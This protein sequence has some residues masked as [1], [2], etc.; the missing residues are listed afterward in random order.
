MNASRMRI[1]RERLLRAPPPPNIVLP[2]HAVNHCHR[3]KPQIQ[4]TGTRV[5]LCCGS[6]Q[7]RERSKFIFSVAYDGELVIMPYNCV[8][9]SAVSL[10]DYLSQNLRLYQLLIY[11]GYCYCLTAIAERLYWFAQRDDLVAITAV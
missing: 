4:R 1:Q 7:Q 2:M 10:V 9:F 6:H 5:L 3:S 8:A 11:R